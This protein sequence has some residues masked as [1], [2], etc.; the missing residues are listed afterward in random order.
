MLI[1][2]ASLVLVIFP[3]IYVPKPDCNFP[4][5]KKHVSLINSPSHICQI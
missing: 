1:N 3:V 5:G 2:A 4:G